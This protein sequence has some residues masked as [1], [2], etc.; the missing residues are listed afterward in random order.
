MAMTDD[1]KDILRTNRS[2]LVDNMADVVRIVSKL[3]ERKTITAHMKESI[4]EGKHHTP[5]DKKWALLDLLPRRGGKAFEEFYNVLIEC[6]ENTA[7]DILKPGATANTGA[8]QPI[9][10]DLPESWPPDDHST[11]NVTVEM[12]AEDNSAMRE[13]FEKSGSSKSMIYRIQR[14]ERGRVLIINNE[15]FSTATTPLE[16]RTGTDADATSISLLFDQLSFKTVIKRNLTQTQMIEALEKESKINHDNYDCFVC[17]ILSHGTREGVFGVDGK[18]ANLE[19]IKDMFNGQNCKTLALKPKLFFIQACQGRPPDSSVSEISEALKQTGIQDKAHAQEQNQVA[20]TESATEKN[21]P[22]RADIFTAEAT[23]PGYMSVR[24]TKH[25]TWFIQ[26]IVYIFGKFAH[27]EDL[28]SM[29]TKVNNLVSR[30]K[31]KNKGDKQV[32]SFTPWLLKT[33]YFFPGLHTEAGSLSQ[34]QETG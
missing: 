21:H 26:A 19:E 17:V 7:A 4:L 1:H 6:D 2:N 11:C 14:S 15:N 34:V 24:N 23:T 18:V 13:L 33:F 22:T 30:G 20:S 16:N 25:G 28:M 5:T 31:T 9:E 27:K 8:S 3:F 32:S 12:V 10:D 29:M